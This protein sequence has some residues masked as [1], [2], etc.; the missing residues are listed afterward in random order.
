MM[1]S[2]VSCILSSLSSP[3]SYV[4]PTNNSITL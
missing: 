4:R 1:T 2:N 3:D